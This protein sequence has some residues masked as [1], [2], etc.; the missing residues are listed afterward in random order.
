MAKLTPDDIIEIRKRV[1][2][3]SKLP[4]ITWGASQLIEGDVP[5]LLKE[6]DQLNVEM[7]DREKSHIDLY[8]ENKELKGTVKSL[9]QMLEQL[10]LSVIGH[11][12]ESTEPYEIAISNGDDSYT[13][14]EDLD[15]TV[16]SY[17][18]FKRHGIN[19]IES[20]IKTTENEL[21]GIKNI[22]E[23]VIRETRDRLSELGLDL[24]ISSV[25]NESY[26]K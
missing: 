24:N 18:I 22:D 3:A 21:L 10:E 25:F 1:Y 2:D 14:I 19:D 16:R 12:D 7:A 17:N 26:K 20:L 6:V 9:R 4:F 5:A 23:K 8:C 11:C 13:P 15:L